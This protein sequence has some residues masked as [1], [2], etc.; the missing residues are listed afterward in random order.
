M[1]P[2]HGS[3]DELLKSK[4]GI[5][6][7]VGCGRNKQDGFVG[8]DKR[9]VPEADIVHDLEV[10]PWPLPDNSCL[11]IIASH[12]VEHI[13]PWLQI[14]LFNELWRILKMGGQLAVS[15]PYGN[16]SGY[17][18]DPTHCS[19]FNATTFRY[20][21]PTHRLYNIYEPR[22]WSIAKGFPVWSVNGNLECLMTKI[23]DTRDGVTGEEVNHG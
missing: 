17:L 20:F 9:P 8:I 23:A 21:D 6:L 22:P 3:I 11:T 13:K 15:V 7:D 19:P 1:T 10:F 14:D 5:R 4:G 2:I 18:Q 12:I 16:S